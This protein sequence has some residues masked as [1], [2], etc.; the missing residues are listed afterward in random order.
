MTVII[1]KG[2]KI[3]DIKN[4]VNTLVLENRGKNLKK[5]AGTVKL[6]IDP[7]EWQNKLRDEW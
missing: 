3:S 5:Y 6:K 2:S 4:R 7:L 1:K